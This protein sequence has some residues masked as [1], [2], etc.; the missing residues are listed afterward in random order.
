MLSSTPQEIK[1]KSL[2]QNVNQNGKDEIK[3]EKKWTGEKIKSAALEVVA[4]RGRAD[5][6]RRRPRGARAAAT[7]VGAPCRRLVAGNL[8]RSCGR[9]PAGCCVCGVCGAHAGALDRAIGNGEEEI[10]EDS[11]NR[12]GEL[13]GDCSRRSS[14]PAGGAAR[15]G[16]WSGGACVHPLRLGVMCACA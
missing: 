1:N 16:A 4:R 5:G 7:V 2:D 9:R 10:R 8:R 3:E 12:K 6:R 13:T 14:L 15:A 11:K